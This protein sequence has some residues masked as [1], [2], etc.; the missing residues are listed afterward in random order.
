MTITTIG[1][2]Q[3]AA[4]SWMERSLDDALFLEWANA[5][6]DKLMHGVL[7]ADNRTWIVPPLRIRLMEETDT[8]TTSGGFVAL[9]ADWLEFKRIWIDANDGQDLEYRPLRQFRA[10]PDSQMT[11]TPAKYTID[12]GNLYIAPTSDADIEVTYYEKLG[13]FTG[14][15]STDAILT[16]HGAVY[17]S[18]VL[19]EAYRW[20]RDPDGMAME[21][22]EF[23]AKVRGLNATDKNVQTSGSIL[24]SRP[25]SVS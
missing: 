1:T 15:A 13:A 8:L 5:V 10:D 18:G 11:G 23:G 7:G 25:Q 17:L 9:P 12:A 21:Q 14:D 3:A 2:L 22:M 20:T 24:V 16:A 6:A 19:C 4:E